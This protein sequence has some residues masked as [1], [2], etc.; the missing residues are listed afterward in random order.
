M[1]TILTAQ[2]LYDWREQTGAM[3]GADL[4][5]L[6][7]D[8]YDGEPSP[9]G[10]WELPM[11]RLRELA[12]QHAD[13]YIGAGARAFLARYGTVAEQVNYH[14]WAGDPRPLGWRST[15]Y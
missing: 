8:L 1:S 10:R 7:R 4:H 3:S 2:T 9:S 14:D 12:E 5:E 6:F 13:T 11:G 15:P